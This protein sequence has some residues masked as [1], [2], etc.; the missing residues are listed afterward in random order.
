MWRRTRSASFRCAAL[1]I[2]LNRLTRRSLPLGKE[3][4][5]WS[6]T[7]AL[8]LSSR[9]VIRELPECGPNLLMV[10]LAWVGFAL[11]R[12]GRDGL[13]GACLGLAIAMK[14]TQA[15]FVPYF[16]LKRQWRMVAATTAFTALFSVAPIVR[17]GPSLYKRHVETWAGN[18]WKGL[19]ASDPVGRRAGPGRGL[20]RLTEADGRAVLMHLPPDH[21]GRIASSWHAEWLD[22]SPPIA[23]ALIKAGMLCFW[24]LVAWR[25]R[26]PASIAIK[27]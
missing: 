9:F 15:L 6:T 5:F 27:T 22:L 11:W 16:I 21:K 24:R 12:R 13:G 18:C 25:F 10:A 23:G 4:L 19:R 20:E 1:V 3:P 26:R 2:V 7:L 8:A 17:Q 14:C